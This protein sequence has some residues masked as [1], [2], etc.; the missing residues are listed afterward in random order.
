MSELCEKCKKPPLPCWRFW[1]FFFALLIAFPLSLAATAASRWPFFPIVPMG[2]T[3]L[4]KAWASDWG[5]Y[6]D[7]LEGGHWR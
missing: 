4:A 7:H 6:A 1:G 5:R 2:V 3:F